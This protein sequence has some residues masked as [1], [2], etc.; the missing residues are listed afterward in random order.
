M[1]NR[2]REATL[3]ALLTKLVVST[4][5]AAKHEDLAKGHRESP[6]NQMRN[7]E[8]AMRSLETAEDAKRQILDLFNELFQELAHSSERAPDLRAATSRPLASSRHP[9]GQAL[10]RENER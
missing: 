1:V 6:V 9:T 10:S 2:N 4:R 7:Q 3:R 8:A 5:V